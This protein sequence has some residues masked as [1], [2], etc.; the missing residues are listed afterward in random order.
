MTFQV[1]YG[2]N[3]RRVHDEVGVIEELIQ[4]LRFPDT[5]GRFQV[6]EVRL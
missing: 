2:D 4:Y 1:R 5:Y 3:F 6:E